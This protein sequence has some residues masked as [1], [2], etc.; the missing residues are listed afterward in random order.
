MVLACGSQCVS[1][2]IPSDGYTQIYQINNLTDYQQF[3]AAFTQ[4]SR[5]LIIGGGLAGCEFAND[6]VAKGYQV[7]IVDIGAY[8]LSA[9]LPVEVSQKLQ[10]QLESLGVKFYF[11][12]NVQN[13]E[14]TENGTRVQLT[15][16]EFIEV[17]ILLSAI[18][19][20]PNIHLARYEGITTNYGIVANEYL[21]TSASRVY[22]VGDCAEV[23][24][25]V[26][27]YILPIMRQTKSLA[28]TLLGN[29]CK[30][31]YD[32]MPIN[33][34]TPALPIA[35]IEPIKSNG[36]WQIEHCNGDM[37]AIY[38]DACDSVLGVVLTGA[39]LSELS[40]YKK[41]IMDNSPIN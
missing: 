30:V 3:R 10:S 15:N 12:T 5:I 28:Q 38:R 18:G 23:N 4:R 21:Q 27:P 6:L 1:T 24:G 9:L 20:R 8:L 39:N 26:L 2:Y 25:F 17:D 34:K 14:K 33:I 22:T 32:V 41:E 35:V 36:Q 19:V 13:T 40:R 37:K 29:A 31:T 7:S 11:N 16:G